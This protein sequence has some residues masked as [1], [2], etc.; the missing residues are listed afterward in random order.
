[1]AISGK[2]VVP[3]SWSGNRDAYIARLMRVVDGSSADSIREATASMVSVIGRTGEIPPEHTGKPLTLKEANAHVDAMETIRLQM[4]ARVN[5]PKLTLEDYHPE[6]KPPPPSATVS[7]EAMALYRAEVEEARRDFGKPSDPPPVQQYASFS[8][9]NIDAVMRH[10]GEKKVASPTTYADYVKSEVE[11]MKSN[12]VNFTFTGAYGT[13]RLTHDVDE[14]IG[15][16]TEAA[17]KK[18]AIAVKLADQGNSESGE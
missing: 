8:A 16:L 11:E 4:A 6:A 15:W 13:D 5:P 18:A 14:Y 1:M 9:L 10:Q 17:S 2:S 7:A 12:S 3:A